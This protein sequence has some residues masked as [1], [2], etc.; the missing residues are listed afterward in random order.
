M[1]QTEGPL[2]KNP[3]PAKPSGKIIFVAYTESVM[4]NAV[5]LSVIVQTVLAYHKIKIPIS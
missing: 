5:I 4:Q 1:V 2:L 3:W